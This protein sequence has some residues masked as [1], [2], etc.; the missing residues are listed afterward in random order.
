MLQGL[1]TAPYKALVRPHP[2]VVER[3]Q[4]K[5]TA[6]MGM[7][8]CNLTPSLAQSSFLGTPSNEVKKIDKGALH[9][10]LSTNGTLTKL[11]R[12]AK[13]CREE[14]EGRPGQRMVY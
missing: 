7:S 14:P 5:G 3:S 6:K 8:G 1:Y 11:T 9:Q 12:I 10:E 2:H 13:E 4:P